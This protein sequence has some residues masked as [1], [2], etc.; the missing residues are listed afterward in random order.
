MIPD[1]IRKSLWR[2]PDLLQNGVLQ[3]VLEN[4][5]VVVLRLAVAWN[6]KS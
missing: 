3:V 5:F 4:G 2:R 6:C 1:N